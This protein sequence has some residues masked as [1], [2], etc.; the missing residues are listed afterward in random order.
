MVISALATVLPSLLNVLS[1]LG[2]SC[3]RQTLGFQAGFF[4]NHSD[5]DRCGFFSKKISN[6]AA[7]LSSALNSNAAW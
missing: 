7:T 5:R 4:N 2:E 3:A 1:Q 6:S